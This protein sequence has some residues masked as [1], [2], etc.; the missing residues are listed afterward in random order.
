MILGEK[1]L[2]KMFKGLDEEQ[3]QPDSIDLKLEKVEGFEPTLN[4]GLYNGEKHLPKMRELLKVNNK[5][6]LQ[7][8]N[9]YIVT[10]ANKMKIPENIAQLYFSRS[11]LMRM[12]L[13]TISCLGDSCFDGYLK[14][15]MFNASDNPIGLDKGE[16]IA[17]CVNFE[18]DAGGIYCGDYN[19]E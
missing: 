4:V 10:I 5:Y 13:I 7:P 12:G 11:S 14:F 9:A 17:T 8:H 18:V 15:L 19:E 6:I 16:R 1:I 2:R 3:Y